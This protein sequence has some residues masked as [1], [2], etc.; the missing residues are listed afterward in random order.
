MSE[1][2]TETNWIERIRYGV[3]KDALDAL[4][5]RFNYYA[6][7]FV[8]NQDAASGVMPYQDAK[9]VTL[10]AAIRDGQREVLIY[11]DNILNNSI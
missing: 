2:D 4:K 1:Q 8:F 3:S 11:L 10:N 9:M 7:A 5:E 6:P